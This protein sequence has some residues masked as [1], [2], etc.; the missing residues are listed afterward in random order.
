[1]SGITGCFSTEQIFAKSNKLIR[2]HLSAMQKTLESD[3]PDIHILDCAAFSQSSIISQENTVS[4]I[5]YAKSTYLLAFC[6]EIYNYSELIEL[7]P[8]SKRTLQN[9]S[10]GYLLL[11]LY[12]ELGA[13]FIQ[14]VNGVFSIA[15]YDGKEKCIYLF[16]DRLGIK[17]LFYTI[18]DDTLVFASEIKALFKFSG[19]EARIDDNS[20]REILAIGPAR[21]EGNGI[22]KDINE[23]KYGSYVRYDGQSLCEEKYWELTAGDELLSYTDTV[24]KT[25]FLLTDAIKRQLSAPLPIASLLSGGLDSAIVTAV[26]RRELEELKTYSFDFKN[27]DNFFIAN[28]F[29]PELDKPY[30]KIFLEQYSCSHSY[31]ECSEPMLFALLKNA[32]DIRD[33]PGMTDIDCSLMYFLGEV[34]RQSSIVLTGECSDEI[35]GGYPWLHRKE[36]Y[37]ADTFPWAKDT[38]SR[39]LPYKKKLIKKLELKEYIKEKYDNSIKNV[40][41]S[42][43]EAGF[44]KRHRE[45]CYLNL[46]HFMTGLLDRMDRAA[47]HNNIIARVPFADYRV[48]EFIWNLP[49]NYKAKDATPK[50]LLRDAFADILPEKIT[51]RKKCPYPKTYNPA[52][53][54]LLK[55]ELT[56]IISNSSSPLLSLV[57]KRAISKILSQPCTNIKPWFGQLM[58]GPQLIAYLIQINYWLEKYNLTL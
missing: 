26:A 44:D 11:K 23:V 28:S 17:P 46:K 2:N 32:V 24:E 3:N 54:G 36:L 14:N 37:Q 21:S 34:S 1:M 38:S 47:N 7:L 58:S 12:L 51:N 31:L 16:R 30:V 9:N 19:I 6:G 4:K 29:Q 18:T 43:G 53:E 39:F 8:Q 35:F 45:L 42:E 10:N 50:A 48:V 49:Y 41:V 22:F 20:L 33:F 55:A 25:R 40:P 5:K 56:R 15:V 52:Y 57:S 13:D 27:S